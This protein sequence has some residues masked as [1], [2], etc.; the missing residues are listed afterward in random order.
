MQ[1]ILHILLFILYIIFFYGFQLPVL[2]AEIHMGLSCSPQAIRK[3]PRYYF[4]RLLTEVSSPFSGPARPSID[5]SVHV[6]LYVLR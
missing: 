1:N 6:Y 4:S 2:L 3:L 5:G